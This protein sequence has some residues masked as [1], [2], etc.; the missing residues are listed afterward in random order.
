MWMEISS[1][2]YMVLRLNQEKQR[3]V[4]LLAQLQKYCY[5]YIISFFTAILG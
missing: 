1:V 2:T 4:Q 5:I 3:K